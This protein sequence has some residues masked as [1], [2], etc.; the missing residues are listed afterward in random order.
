MRVCPKALW[1]IFHARTGPQQLCGPIQNIITQF[2]GRTSPELFLELLYYK[3]IDFVG[4]CNYTY[5]NISKCSLIRFKQTANSCSS[6]HKCLLFLRVSKGFDRG[7]EGGEAIRSR[8]L[9]GKIKN[10]R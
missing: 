3:A 1:H 10:K 5:M 8:A 2:S 4:F 9:N 7:L 6:S